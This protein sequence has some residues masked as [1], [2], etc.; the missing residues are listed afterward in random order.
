MGLPQ[1]FSCKE[2]T[3]NA[4]ATGDAVL[5]PGLGRSPGGGHSIKRK[6]VEENGKIRREDCFMNYLS[7]PFRGE[8]TPP[9][10]Q[11]IKNKSRG[12]KKPL[13]ESESGE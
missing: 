2:S 7:R 10:F 5:I 9:F 6:N 8:E 4:R 1:W 12:T 13:D 3:Y 11:E